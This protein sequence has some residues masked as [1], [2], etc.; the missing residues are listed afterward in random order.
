MHDS[1][2]LLSSLS[3]HTVV[4]SFVCALS[5]LRFICVT[6]FMAQENES[7]EFHRTLLDG[8]VFSSS[9]PLLGGAGWSLPS[10]GWCCLLRLL[11]S[12]TALLRL[13]S[14]LGGVLFSGEAAPPPK[15]R[16]REATPSKRRRSATTQKKGK[17]GNTTQEEEKRHHPPPPK[18]MSKFKTCLFAK[19]MQTRWQQCKMIFARGTL[20][21]DSMI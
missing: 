12:G 5:D 3:G 16:G 15:R 13:S 20:Q 21:I 6:A 11:W 2:D 4:S 17:R 19:I 9:P 7:P 1:C 18:N 8:A 10:F 14:F